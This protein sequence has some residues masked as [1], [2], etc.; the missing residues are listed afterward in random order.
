M[1]IKWSSQAKKDLQAI[2]AYIARDSVNYAQG[3]VARIVGRV[4]K[5]ATHPTSGHRVHECLELPF[6]EVHE[7]NYRVIYRFTEDELSVVTIVHMKQQL[8]RKRLS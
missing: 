7:G 1:T 3:Q 4:E 2:Y 6:R 5:A 8:P